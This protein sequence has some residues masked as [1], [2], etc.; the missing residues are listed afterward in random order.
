MP[1]AKE[2]FLFARSGCLHRISCFQARDS[3]RS[4]KGPESAAVSGTDRRWEAPTI[5]GT[6]VVLPKGLSQKRAP[7]H[8]LIKKTLDYRM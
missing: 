7:L 4:F 3:T 8:N 1:E 2:V 6:S 5:L